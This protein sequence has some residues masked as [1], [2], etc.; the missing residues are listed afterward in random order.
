M[1][2]EQESRQE[3]AGEEEGDNGQQV[4]TEMRMRAM[5]RELMRPAL[6]AVWGA[7]LSQ[8]TKGLSETVI[9]NKD[10]TSPQALGYSSLWF[11][12]SYVIASNSGSHTN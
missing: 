6:S 1:Q 9:N 7:L 2:G 12:F 3:G 10:N 4:L 5:G 8:G 11:M